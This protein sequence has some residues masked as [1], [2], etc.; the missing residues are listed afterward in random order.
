[1]TPVIQIERIVKRCGGRFRA[2]AVAY[3][4]PV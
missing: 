4:K 3:Q 2:G 1:M